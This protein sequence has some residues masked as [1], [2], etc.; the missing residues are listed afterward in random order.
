MGK[1][2][3]KKKSPFFSDFFEKVHFFQIF[4]LKILAKI[5]LWKSLWKFLSEKKSIFSDFFLRKK[6]HFFR[7]FRLKKS[8]FFWDFFLW[9]K[10]YV[11]EIFFFEKKSMFFRFF[12]LK[13]SPFFSDFFLWK[14]DH[15]FQIFFFEKVHFFQ[16]F[17]L[18]KTCAMTFR[19]L[20]WSGFDRNL[21]LFT[22]N[23][24]KKV[25]LYC[26]SPV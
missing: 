15:F 10:V 8:P 4:S 9:K 20:F 26:F 11:F 5:F 17:F 2:I 3:P 14:K 7:F 13:K 16:I 1:I 12:S 25:L 6:V 18:Y 22:R 23:F 24:G 21:G 19:P